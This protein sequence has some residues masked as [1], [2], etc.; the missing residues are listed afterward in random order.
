MKPFK[1]SLLFVSVFLQLSFS[2]KN[3]QK[4]TGDSFVRFTVKNAGVSVNGKFK[5]FTTNI[6]F[7]KANIQKSVFNGIIHVASIDTDIKKRDEHLKKEEYFDAARHTGIVFVSSSVT[8][9]NNNTLKVTG[10]LTIKATTKPIS[11]DI[12]YSNKG[13]LTIFDT[14]LKL[15]RRDYGVGKESL[16]MSDDVNVEL[17]ISVKTTSL[18]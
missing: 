13:D 11:L 12:I 5:S 16:I 15:N 4:T 9:V 18:K 3:D 8:P 2:Q 6:K 14:K 10:N 7:N 1:L 17:R